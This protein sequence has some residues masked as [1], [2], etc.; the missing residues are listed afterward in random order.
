MKLFYQ[1]RTQSKFYDSRDGNGISFYGLRIK[2]HKIPFWPVTYA[3]KGG[4]M[5]WVIHICVYRYVYDIK[6]KYES[7][8]KIFLWTK[9]RKGLT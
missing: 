8:S 9:R 4:M 6:K 3:V 1:E 5:E 2:G 7:K